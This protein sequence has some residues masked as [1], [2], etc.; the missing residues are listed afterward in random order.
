MK[1]RKLNVVIIIIYILLVIILAIINLF[2]KNKISTFFH[3]DLMNISSLITSLMIGIYF[4]NSQSKYGKLLNRYEILVI[5]FQ[6]FFIDRLAYGNKNELLMHLKLVRNKF[7][8]IYR[9]SH[10]INS[11]NIL[12]ELEIISSNIKEYDDIISNNLEDI[13][14]V[15][16]DINRIAQVINV[17]CDD[18]LFN[19][20]K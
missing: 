5:E 18:I 3:T 8:N 12:K 14:L 4:I 15:I 9:Y 20:Y 7:N 17:K 1:G 6:N 13:N 16:D 11:S 10:D 19:M 2:F